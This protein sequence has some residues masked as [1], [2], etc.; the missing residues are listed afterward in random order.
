[1]Y[2]VYIIYSAAVDVYYKG[3]TLDYDK[4]LE[5]HNDNKSRYTAHKGPWTLIFVQEFKDKSD[6]LKR[7]KQLKRQN[8]AY[9]EWLLNQEINIKRIETK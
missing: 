7:E 9:L 1:M 6:A 3:Y 2:Y 8:R 5:Q 4:R